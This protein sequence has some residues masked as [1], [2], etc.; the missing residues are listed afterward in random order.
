MKKN[1]NLKI[2]NFWLKAGALLLLVILV[3]GS[4]FY[5]FLTPLESE[6]RIIFLD[7]GQGDAILIQTKAKN[8]L[9]DGGPDREIVYKLIST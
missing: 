2:I 9:I 6:L 5:F 1:L 8:I 4:Y 3:I 7:I